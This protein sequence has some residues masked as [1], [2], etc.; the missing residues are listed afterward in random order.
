MLTLGVS[1][2]RHL[3][4]F[5]IT[6]IGILFAGHVGN[7]NDSVVT[8]DGHADI[9]PVL[10]VLIAIGSSIGVLEYFRKV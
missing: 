7:S 5:G 9:S 1:I 4:R 2:L 3:V 8:R 6:S 10:H